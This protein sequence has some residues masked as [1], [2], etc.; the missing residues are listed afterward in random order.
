MDSPVEWRYDC[1]F[2]TSFMVHAYSVCDD[3]DYFHNATGVGYAMNTSNEL[4]FV[5]EVAI[6]TG[7]VLDPVYR[8]KEKARNEK[9]IWNAKFPRSSMRSSR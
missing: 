9:Q 6:S 1:W 8:E 7:V 5:K 4:Q 2:G 3:P